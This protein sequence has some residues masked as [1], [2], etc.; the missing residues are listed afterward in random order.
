[1]RDNA[2]A[3]IRNHTW[4]IRS[5]KRWENALQYFIYIQYFLLV[6]NTSSK[7][8]PSF[9]IPKFPISIFQYRL[10][11]TINYRRITKNSN[12]NEYFQFFTITFRPRRS[13]K[14]RIARKEEKSGSWRTMHLFFVSNSE[15]WPYV[16]GAARMLRRARTTFGTWARGRPRG[17]T[18][19]PVP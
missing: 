3:L 18:R 16:W 2:L 5:I 14:I 7:Y 9:K 10:N 6:S 4:T 11:S 1:M 17:W 13:S 12:P 15:W 19:C 8:I